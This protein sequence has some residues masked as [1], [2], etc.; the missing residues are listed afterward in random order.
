MGGNKVQEQ[1]LVLQKLQALDKELNEIGKARELL[2]SEQGALDTDLERIHGMVESLGEELEGLRG[3]RQELVRDLDQEKENIAKSEGRLPA[4]KTQ[5]EYVAVLKEIDTAKKQSRDLEEQVEAKN[6]EMAGVEKDFQEK[7]SEL[8]ELQERVES[9]RSEIA[10]LLGEHDD[11]VGAKKTSRSDLFDELP[12]PLRK[13]YQML[14]ERRNGVAI[15]AARRGTCLGCNMQLPPQLFNS[16][17][18][19]TEIMT[20][21]HCSRLIFLAADEQG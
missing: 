17:Y 3:Q 10:A 15:V 21:P 6:G 14:V 9:R 18:T 7:E 4:I 11:Q 1:V 5:K 8:A 12:A 2:E 16:L 19:A 20:C 13:R